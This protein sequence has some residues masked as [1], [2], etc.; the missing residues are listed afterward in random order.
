[1]GVITWNGVASTSVNIQVE[2]QPHYNIAERDYEYIHV[3]GR[4]GDFLI[5]SGG[6][7]NVK[8]SY[9]ICFIDFDLLDFFHAAHRVASWLSSAP[10][11]AVLTDTYDP[12]YYRLATFDSDQKL[13]DLLGKAGRATIEFNCKPQRFLLS[14]DDAIR[15]STSGSSVT[16]PLDMPS[17]PLITV[18]GTGAGTL[19]VG[20]Y[21]VIFDS[22]S[23]SVTVDSEVEDCYK[24][25]STAS[26]AVT[27]TDG[28]PI[29]GIGNT[30]IEFSGGIT[31]VDVVPKWWTL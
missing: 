10:G 20:S 27:L 29:L 19:H 16:N 24:A 26:N 25:G 22:I 9:D 21:E 23:E 2:H 15:I 4:N 8:Q 17:R 5:D 18:Y 3:P 1:M 7:K 6:W 31:H 13:T 14:G 30:G 12:L 28:Y 11:Y